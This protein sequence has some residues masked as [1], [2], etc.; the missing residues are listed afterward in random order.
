MNTDNFYCYCFILE[1]CLPID[2]IILSCPYINY[3]SVWS[4]FF[5]PF[6]AEASEWEML[7]MFSDSLCLYFRNTLSDVALKYSS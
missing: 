3:F 4:I 1:F 2:K 7:L 6:S 5:C